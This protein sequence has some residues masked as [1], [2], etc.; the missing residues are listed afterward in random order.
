MIFAS[1]TTFSHYNLKI[2]RP[3]VTKNIK[4]LLKKFGEFW[5]RYFNLTLFWLFCVAFFCNQK[6]K[7]FVSCH[8]LKTFRLRYFTL[9]IFEYFSS[10]VNWNENK[11]FFFDL[12]KL[13]PL[14]AISVGGNDPIQIKAGLPSPK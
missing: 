11:Q 2:L 7:M 8:C 12:T 6:V 14:P 3:K 10:F 13:W 4:N 1:K 5:T 9:R